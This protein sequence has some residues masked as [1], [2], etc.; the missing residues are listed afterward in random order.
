MSRVTIRVVRF[1]AILLLLVG[2]IY[3]LS[4]KNS[5]AYSA[6]YGSLL[7]N[8]QGSD[9]QLQ[10]QQ[11]LQ[12]SLKSNAEI[13]HP[14]ANA[15]F[16]TLARNKDVWSMIESIR[17]IE[18]RFNHKYKYDWVFLNDEDF[19]DR[20]KELTSAII[21][22][23]TTYARI[24]KEHWSYPDWIDQDKAKE[25]R[26]K[27]REAKII[28]GGSESYRHMCRYESGFFWRHPAL[29]KYKYYWRVEP[30]IKIFCDINYDVFKY[31]EDHKLRYGFTISLHEYKATIPTLWDST[32]KFMK[33]HPEML[34]K[35]NI[36]GFVSGNE[37]KDYNR[38]HFWSNF[39]VADLDFWREEA[40][41]KYF[42]FLDHEGGFFYERWGDA[43]VH[44]IGASLFLNK[45]EVHHF[46]D[47]G[48]WH[49]PF[50]N[51][52]TLKQTRM[53]NKCVCDPEENF[54]WKGY[55]CTALFYKVTGREV[56]VDGNNTN[57]SD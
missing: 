50:N 11:Q 4:T 15:T 23:N 9:G 13:S 54:A 37:G 14:R 56:P 24:P 57:T 47:I 3:H 29:N 53:D 36:M 26:K 52:P 41:T 7:K 19:D 30:S 21:S 42:D 55:S 43:P 2:L 51:C 46:E 39:E 17:A 6:Y 38:C 25:A 18:D 32:V 20:F 35:D 16:V 12:Q 44:S 34:A 28:Y 10:P 22:G 33:Q 31:M 5:N 27:M 45:S 8:A 40:Y 1:A 48:Y 49:V